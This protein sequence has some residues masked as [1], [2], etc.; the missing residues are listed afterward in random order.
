MSLYLT[1]TSI[2]SAGGG[3]GVDSPPLEAYNTFGDT[4][5]LC[6]GVSHLGPVISI[7]SEITEVHINNQ[8]VTIFPDPP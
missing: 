3:R 7:E 2:Q 4:P 5:L 8:A 1:L 6:G